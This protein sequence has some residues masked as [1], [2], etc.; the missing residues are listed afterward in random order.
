V[1]YSNDTVNPDYDSEQ[2]FVRLDAT[3][4]RTT[5]GADLG[6]GRLSGIPG[7]NGNV[8][9]R[10]ELSRKISASSTLAA[11]FGHQYSDA[12]A[13][14]VLAQ[15]IGGASNLNTQAT[16]QTGT[17]FASTYG[18]LGWNFQR[19][20]TGF[21]I[22]AAYYKESYIDQHALDDNRTQ[23]D[24]QASR[25]LTPTLK[26]ALVGEYLRDNFPNSPGTATEPSGQAQLTWKAG[27]YLSVFLDY[28]IA[29]RHSN[30]P[31]SDFTEHRVWLSV[32]YGREAEKPP[33]PPTPPL[34]G[35]AVSY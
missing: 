1:S 18:T 22:T 29:T 31:D 27:R 21:G 24:A 28:S 3:G 8:L 32:G 34:P 20:R 2:A 33:G 35:R 10:L 30:I 15:T 6:Y 9:A 11:S 4:G 14:F 26:F 19:L 25:L 16:Q 5:V 7:S 17:P 12:A 23:I 13:A